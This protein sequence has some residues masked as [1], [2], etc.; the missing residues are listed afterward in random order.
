MKELFPLVSIITYCYN[1]ERFVSRFFEGVL[2]QTYQ[3]IELIFIDN[4]SEDDTSG[5]ARDYIPKLEARGITVQFIRYEK[6]Q[7]TCAMKQLGFRKM[8][9]E[10]FCGC[11][12][13]DVM[14]PT[15]IEEMS[16]FLRDH[17][18]KG[19]VFCQLNQIQESTGEKSGVMKTVRKSEPKAAFLDMLY[20]RNTIFTPL[21]YMMSRKHFLTVNPEM[22]IH[23]SKYGENYQVQL[24]F[25]YYDLQGYIEKPL[26]DY[27]VR[28]N[29]Y[30]GTMKKDPMKQI[31][32]FKGQEE[33]ILATLEQIHPDNIESYQAIVQKRLR[34]DRFYASVES[35]NKAFLQMCWE[36]LKEVQG[37]S[38]QDTL[39]YRFPSA[40]MLM[41]RLIKDY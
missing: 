25:L 31:A 30:S 32:A 22:K 28:S 17:P 9:G 16:G 19:I 24:P 36:E 33:A 15:Y 10:F 13:D 41:R 26:G 34:R 21:C 40:Y 14:H 37:G 5:A 38:L 11:D 29:S 6:N 4:G 7:S 18:E 23:I 3:N 1:G 8:R 35:K 27:Y 12:S 20:A 39:V 2:S